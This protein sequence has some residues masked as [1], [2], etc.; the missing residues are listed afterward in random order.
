MLQPYSR[1]VMDRIPTF[2]LIGPNLKSG[3]GTTRRVRTD[4]Q[5]ITAYRTPP[6]NLVTESRDPMMQYKPLPG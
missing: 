3:S 2:D 1:N 4:G 6:C 5:K